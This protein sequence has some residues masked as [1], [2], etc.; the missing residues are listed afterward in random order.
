MIEIDGSMG[1][2]GGQILRTSLALAALRREALRI[3][4]IRRKR[5]S[6]GLAS[7]H[8]VSVQAIQQ[9][10]GGRVEGARKGS[11]E[12]VFYPGRIQRG[13]YVIDIGTA[14]SISMVIQ[15]I[16]PACIYAPGDVELAVKGG[17]D[18]KWS[19]PVDYVKRVFIPFLCKMGVRA[20][21]NIERRGYYPRGGGLVRA[22]VSPVKRLEKVN[23]TDR[24]RVIRIEG[25]AH[26]YNLPRHIVE[27]AAAAAERKLGY[28]C[29]I[30]LESYRG[31]ST[32]MGI[33]LWAVCDNSILGA[34]A[35]GEIGKRAENVGEEA[36]LKLLGE[37]N[38]GAPI[39]SHLG[40]QIIPY[41]ALA[42]GESTVRVAEITPHLRTNIDV[43]EEI[44]NVRFRVEGDIVRVKGVGFRTEL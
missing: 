8:L 31:F 36:A 2:G 9:L 24:G 3:S 26:S 13:S 32:G 44:L 10:T 20:R 22:A 5:P 41:L 34:S 17:T 4:N 30:R 6:P 11:T 21:V 1:E 28:P 35:L 25:I 16:L 18:V 15:T 39:D 33:V 19:P 23:L 14:G 38:S 27:R 37:L 7:Q 43:V 40:D 29:T 42:R 12:L